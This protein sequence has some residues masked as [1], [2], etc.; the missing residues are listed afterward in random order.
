MTARYFGIRA[1]GFINGALYASFLAGIAL[2]PVVASA[3]FDSQHNYQLALYGAAATLL[4]AAA[5]ATRL[6]AYPQW[7]EAVAAAGPRKPGSGD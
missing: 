6:G 5:M 1:Y 3:L 2:G 7:N 4:L